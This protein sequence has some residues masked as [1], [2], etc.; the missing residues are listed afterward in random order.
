MPHVTVNGVVRRD[1]GR[2]VA[3]VNGMNTLTGDFGAQRID[4]DAGS[5]AVTIRT[6]GP[7]PEVKLKPGQSFEPGEDRVVDVREPAPAALP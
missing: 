3:W 4:V 6:P 5:G 1:D 7:R 2:G